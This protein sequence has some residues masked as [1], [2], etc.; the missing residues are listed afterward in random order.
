VV[1]L[2]QDADLPVEIGQRKENH[3]AQR[4]VDTLIGKMYGILHQ[5]LILGRVPAGGAD[6]TVIM[7]GKVFE[8][9]VDVCFISARPAVYRVTGDTQC[10]AYLSVA[11]SVKV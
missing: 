1:T 9:S 10:R 11:G 5:C 7:A 3:F 2:H 8:A 6:H 4:V